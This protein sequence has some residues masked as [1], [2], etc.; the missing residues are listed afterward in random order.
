VVLGNKAYLLFT[1]DKL[2]IAVITIVLLFKDLFCRPLSNCSALQTMIQVRRARTFTTSSR[3]MFKKASHHQ[4][5]NTGIMSLSICQTMQLRCSNNSSVPL[6][7]ILGRWAT[8]T[9]SVSDSCSARFQRFSRSTTCALIL[10]LL[11]T[12]RNP[13]QS[14]SHTLTCRLQNLWHCLKHTSTMGEHSCW[15]TRESANRQGTCQ[16]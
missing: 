7:T 16:P 2:I 15:E 9:E 1:F 6:T 5:V 3:L 13:K 11:Q 4:Q 8:S 14:F 12:I 10:S